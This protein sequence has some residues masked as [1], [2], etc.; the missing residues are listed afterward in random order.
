MRITE[1]QVY[2]LL[3]I[4]QDSI[5]SDILMDES[6]TIDSQQRCQLIDEIKGQQNNEIMEIG[7][8]QASESCD[9]QEGHYLSE[10]VSLLMKWGKFFEEYEHIP[11]KTRRDFFEE[12]SNFINNYNKIIHKPKEK[13]SSKKGES[14]Y[15]SD[16]VS[17]LR[18]WKDDGHSF[19]LGISTNDFLSKYD[20]SVTLMNDL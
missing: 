19:L 1:Q 6:F 12:T 7:E 11:E 3:Q 9:I 20:K 8:N 10:S 15:L 13:E 4:A 17:L 18:L 14:V 16:C 2:T 5:R